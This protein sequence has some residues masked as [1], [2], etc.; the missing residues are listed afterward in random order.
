MD[1]TTPPPIPTASS[2]APPM[3]S[4]TEDKTVAILSYL[5][6]IGF[7]VAIVMHSSKKTQ[8]GAFHLRQVLGIFLTA[9][10]VMVCEF[11]LL[12]I[13]ILGWLCI[14][15]LWVSMFALWVM[16]LIAA[17]KGEMKPVPI[18]GP[19]YQKWFGNAFN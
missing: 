5:T 4:A 9:L 10:A 3:A 6:L 17:V 1:Q 18:L 12:F 14:F 16:G 15:A 8:L 7:I 19:M 2:A 13:P 11:V